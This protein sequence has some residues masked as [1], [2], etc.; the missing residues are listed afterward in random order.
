MVLVLK[1]DK[2]NVTDG[3]GFFPYGISGMLS[4]SATCFFAFVGFDVIATTGA[5]I[6]YNSIHLFGKFISAVLEVAF[7]VHF[8]RDGSHCLVHI[9][10]LDTVG[11][12]IEFS[13]S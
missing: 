1:D 4:G 2:T 7:F 8:E 11:R 13:F 5:N 3:G 12:L 6:F 10:L 9:Q